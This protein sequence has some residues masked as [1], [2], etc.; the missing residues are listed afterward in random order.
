[1]LELKFLKWFLIFNVDGTNY[2]IEII[3]PFYQFYKIRMIT[4]FSL[5][6][7][8]QMN[9]KY[10]HPRLNNHIFLNM[11]LITC[12]GLGSDDEDPNQ[13]KTQMKYIKIN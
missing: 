12:F 3:K 1:M 13:K 7:V 10:I 6:S 5:S 9:C 8:N 2:I 4:L 11:E